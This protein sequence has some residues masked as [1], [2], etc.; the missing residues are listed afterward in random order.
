MSQNTRQS[1]G[2]S[3]AI[4]PSAKIILVIAGYV[5]AVVLA[6]V[7]VSIYVA[8][9]DG[10]DRQSSSGMYAFG[11]SILFLAV[12]GVAAIPATGAALFFLRPYPVFWRAGSIAA[13]CIA[14]TGIAALI[15]SLLRVDGPSGFFGAWS[16][17]SPLRVLLAP[18]FAI[19]F[20]L[21]VLFTPTRSSR[22]MLLS[23]AMIEV[24]VF[25]SVAFLWFHSLH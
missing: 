1:L 20:F 22:I 5:V 16:T 21:S 13:L 6:G 17:V 9:T 18:L 25:A 7:V 11:D 12:F 2:R 14:M 23:A 4:K 19:A 15:G 10:P 3:V 8:L 24:V